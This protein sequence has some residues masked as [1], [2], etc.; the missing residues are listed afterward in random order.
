VKFSGKKPNDVT[1]AK[2]YVIRSTNKGG[3]VKM[4]IF[5]D[6]K[7]IGKLG[8]KSYLSWEVDPTKGDIM[9]ISK[10]ENKDMLTISPKAGKTYYIKQ[11]IKMGWAVVRTELEFLEENEAKEMLIDLK[12]PEMKYA[13]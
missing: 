13:E 6:D 3:G 9:I 1:N 5:Q 8:T 7:L 10:S 11:K 4:R 2:I 12:N